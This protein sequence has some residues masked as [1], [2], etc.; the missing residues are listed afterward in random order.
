MVERNNMSFTLILLM[1]AFI[2]RGSALRIGGAEG[3]EPAYLIDK[4]VNS[5][6]NVA[7]VD[8]GAAD[9]DFQEDPIQRQFQKPHVHGILV[10]PNPKTFETLQAKA[11]AQFGNAKRIQPLNVALSNT[12][13]FMKFFVVSPKFAED[14]PEAPD[15]M[16]H[17]LSTTTSREHITKHWVTGPFWFKPLKSSRK[18]SQ[19]IFDTYV[20]E[21]TVPAKAPKDILA[22]GGMEAK[23]V[24]LLKVDVEGFDAVCVQAFMAVPNFKPTVIMFETMH[25]STDDAQTTRELLEAREYDCQIKK[26]VSEDL[27]CWQR[28]FRA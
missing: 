8:I 28:D 1:F 4:L 16:K 25:L 5:S 21:L 15:W 22:L 26:G 18:W 13:G 9:G 24:D 17:Q 2:S 11:L 6:G 14:Y 10:E 19:E 3:W 23:D 20:E 7:I 12:S 27:I